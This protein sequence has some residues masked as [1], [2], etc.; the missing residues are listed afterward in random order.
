MLLEFAESESLPALKK[1][2]LADAGR[3]VARLH[4]HEA[5]ISMI[6]DVMSHLDL[7]HFADGGS[8]GKFSVP[9]L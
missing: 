3:M 6:G 5:Q 9:G 4:D 1:R 8:I 2:A 7:R